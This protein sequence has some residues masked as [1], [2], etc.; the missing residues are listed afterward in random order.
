MTSYLDDFGRHII[1][2]AAKTI[3]GLVQVNLQFAHAKIGNTH[4]TLIVQQNVV[5]L[6]IPVWREKKIKRMS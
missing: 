3:S 5:Q 6:E 1:G 2:C 4:M